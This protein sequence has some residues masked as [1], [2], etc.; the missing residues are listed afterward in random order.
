MIAAV[1]LTFH[2][3]LKI[4]TEELNSICRQVS[5]V[6][7]VDNGSSWDMDHFLD[8]LPITTVNK[9]DM[10]RF[11][12]N[13]G[14]G[15]GHNHGIEW[16]K[17]IGASHVLILDDDSIPDLNMVSRLFS[18]I[19]KLE[20]VGVP[21]AAVGPRYID[22]YS[23]NVS[24]FVRLGLMALRRVPCQNE[25]GELIQT[26]FLISSGLLI[27]LTV[28]DKIG[29]MDI[30]FF[31]DHVDTEWML[32]AHAHGYQAYGVCD[33]LMGHSLGSATRRIWLGHWR[34][35][36]IHSPVRHYYVFRNTILLVRR[37]YSSTRWATNVLL[38]LFFIMIFFIVFI[39][40]RHL[41]LKY[42]VAGIVDGFS[43]ITGPIGN[44]KR[45]PSPVSM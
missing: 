27:P 28:I 23:G 29:A 24:G 2:P 32:R 7:I 14:V 3:D 5:R 35:I 40:E 10:Y 11:E 17:C 38:R 36:P 31:I 41:R 42:I 44:K 34:N 18:A 12:V 8:R 19:T 1:I 9:I 13:V 25:D 20:S 26:D 39:P 15:A 6:L 30:D 16:A 33:A 22:R 45:L 4:L 37:R 43:G 21:V